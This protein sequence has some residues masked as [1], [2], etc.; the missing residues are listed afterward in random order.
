[1][2]VKRSEKGGTTFYA[3]LTVEGVKKEKGRRMN[4]FSA[5]WHKGPW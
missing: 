3:L 4:P 1:M 5:F 2:G